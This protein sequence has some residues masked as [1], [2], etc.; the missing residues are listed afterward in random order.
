MAK[1]KTNQQEKKVQVK[2]KV[3][4]RKKNTRRHVKGEIISWEELEKDGRISMTAGMDKY[5]VEIKNK[6]Q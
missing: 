3:Q 2:K 1:K 6:V 4:K 5:C